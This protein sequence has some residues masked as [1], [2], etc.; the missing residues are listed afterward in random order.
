MGN[1]IPVIVVHD[2]HANVSEE[3]VNLT[4]AL[5]TYK[6][7]PHLDAKDRGLQAARIMANVVSGKVKP[8][9]ALVK[10][11]YALQHHLSQL[12]RRAFEAHC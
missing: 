4:T 7:C 9:Q 5:I 12:I 10:P 2:F 11:P 8:V 6:E 3:I 1:Q